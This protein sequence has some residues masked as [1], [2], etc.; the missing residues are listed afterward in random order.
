MLSFLAKPFGLILQFL[1]GI[2]GNYG[3]SI[4]ILSAVIRIAMYPLYKKQ[5]VS[6]SDMTEFSQKSQEIQKKYAND[7]EMMNQKLTELQK[8]TG[9]N[10]ASGCLPIFVQ[11]IVISGLFVLL[12]Y[13]LNYITDE[14]MVFAVHESFLWIKDLCQPDPWILPILSGISTFISFNMTA[15]N[16]MNVGGGSNPTTKIMKYVFPIMIMWLAH[17]YPAG[18]AIYWFISQ[19]AQIFFNL[20]FN[21]LRQQLLDEKEREKMKEARVAKAAK[22]AKNAK[23]AKKN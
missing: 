21:K 3:L 16:P 1:Y 11:M 20:R 14:G 19:F 13:P 22:A 17:S 15:Q 4:V 9:Y 8:E 12:R 6:T 7:K 18:I 10:P 2:I 5:I 23:A